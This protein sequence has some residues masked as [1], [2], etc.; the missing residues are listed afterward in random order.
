MVMK[1]KNF[2]NTFIL[3]GITLTIFILTTHNLTKPFAFIAFIICFGYF[4]SVF[5]FRKRKFI[6]IFYSGFISILFL[7]GSTGWF[8]SPFFSYLYITA[9]A[10]AFL[11]DSLTSSLFV[12]V[13]IGVFLPHIGEK[14]LF[15][16]ILS[17][18]SLLFLVPLSHYLSK[19]YLN[20]KV[21][22]KKI[23]IL[24]EDNKKTKDSFEKIMT[25]K[26]SLLAANIREPLNDIKQLAYYIKQTKKI[27]DEKI[28]SLVDKTVGIIDDFEKKATGVKIHSHK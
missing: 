5:L 21:G 23:M 13:I 11:F 24:E 4:L 17:L 2:L 27:E 26:I 19:K 10:I 9:I 16:D 7:I 6:V 25:N 8:H 28:I 14:D 20:L 1:T 12:A 15:L 3:P 22:E 18:G